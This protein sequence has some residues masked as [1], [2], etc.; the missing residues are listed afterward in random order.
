MMMQFNDDEYDRLLEMKQQ[1]EIEYHYLWVK[2][3]DTD[4]KINML[5][6]QAQKCMQ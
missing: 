1:L 4:T 6:A 2:L 3:M 5:E